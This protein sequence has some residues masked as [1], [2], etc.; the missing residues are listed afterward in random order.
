MK[1]FLTLLVFSFTAPAFALGF[2]SFSKDNARL[3]NLA[4]EQNVISVVR[5]MP[6]LDLMAER[7]ANSRT[8]TLG[9]TSFLATMVLDDNWDTYFQLKQKGAFANPGVWK[10]DALKAGVT[11]NYAGGEIKIQDENGNIGLTDNKGNTAFTSSDELFDLL[12][13]KSS[14][15]TFDGLVTYAVI[16]NFTPLSGNEGTITLRKG[17]D[18]LYYYS[19]TPDVQVG[20]YPRWLLAINGVLYGLKVTDADAV[21]VSKPI[22]MKGSYFTSERALR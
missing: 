7:D 15:V 4:R 19:M 2:D 12:Y 13:T 1:Y 21:F 5:T 18:G 3:M 16:R 11:F 9:T 17:S 6:L 10:E 14:A 8:I 22:E 20:S